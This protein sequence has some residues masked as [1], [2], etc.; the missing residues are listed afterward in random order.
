MHHREQCPA[1]AA[2]PDPANEG[3]HPLNLSVPL[4]ACFSVLEGTCVLPHTLTHRACAV[5]TCIP[6]ITVSP[7]SRSYEAAHGRQGRPS[8]SQFGG[9]GLGYSIHQGGTYSWPSFFSASSGCGEPPP[10]RSPSTSAL[11]SVGTR[12]FGLSS[13][14]RFLPGPE[15]PWRGGGSHRA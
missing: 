7:F 4:L 8:P 3:S 5:D 13:R 15:G 2:F 12:Q 9:L 6:S 14:A 11:E 1:E 10:S